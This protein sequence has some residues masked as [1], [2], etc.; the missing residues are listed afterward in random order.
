VENISKQLLH[1][2][3]VSLVAG[4]TKIRNNLF[5]KF[6]CWWQFVIERKLHNR[7]NHSFAWGSNFAFRKKDYTTI[8]GLIPFLKIHKD[9]G[10]HFWAEDL[11]LSLALQK[12]GKIFYAL[13][14]NIYTVMPQEK[15]SIKAQAAI[16]QKQMEDNKKLFSFFKI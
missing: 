7:K 15:A 8:G 5:W 1:D 13:H 3:S 16:V 6:S 4:Y 12:V 9:L 10:T 11:Y 2:N 14:A